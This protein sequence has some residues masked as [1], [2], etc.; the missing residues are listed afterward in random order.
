MS[1]Q[2]SISPAAAPVQT[3]SAI[4]PTPGNLAAAQG[5]PV[6][7]L[8]MPEKVSIRYDAAELRRNLQD[9]IAKL[10]QQIQKS[11]QNL[12][13]SID[14]CANRFVITV[15]NTQSGEVIRQ[16]PD[17]VVLKVAHNIDQIK[18]MLLNEVI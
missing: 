3:S 12:N 5:K 17:E 8:R 14:K 18:G 1:N 11:Q 4:A 9:A 7:D 13:F 6:A 10:N 16:I 2:L 15:K